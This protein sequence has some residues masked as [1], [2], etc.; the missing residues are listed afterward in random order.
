M[1]S[2][3]DLMEADMPESSVV[4]A[5]DDLEEVTAG[6]R[7]Y[8]LVERGLSS[9]TVASYVPRARRFL[10]G[11]DGAGGV[12]LAELT[13]ADVSGFLAQECPRQGPGRRR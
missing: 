4:V 12:R 10:A 3:V 8:L 9:E 13:A 1:S 7:R 2:F 6:Y 11:R 5:A